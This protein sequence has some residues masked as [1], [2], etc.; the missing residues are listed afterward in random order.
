MCRAFGVH[1]FW[2]TL[3]VLPPC[4]HTLKNLSLGRATITWCHNYLGHHVSLFHVFWPKVGRA[5][6][7]NL[8]YMA[9]ISVTCRKW[10]N[11]GMVA[12]TKKLT[13]LQSICTW[14]WSIAIAPTE[15]T[16]TRQHL[17][18][19]WRIP[20][21]NPTESGTFWNP[22]SDGYLKSDHYGFTN[23]CFSPI[24]LLFIQLI[25]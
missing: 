11:N 24:Y 10:L 2:P 16:T 22:K 9:Q 15:L 12:R 20:N 23:C 7:C 25:S 8:R 19:M 3:Y 14:D 4:R 21:P 1:F 13:R 18:G 5:S 6:N 17:L